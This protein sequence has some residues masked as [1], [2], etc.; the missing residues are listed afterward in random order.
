MSKRNHN[1]IPTWHMRHIHHATL[2]YEIVRN[3]NDHMMKHDSIE[4][5]TVNASAKNWFSTIN[6][7][8]I[9]M[10]K[11]RKSYFVHLP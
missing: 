10:Y 8:E 11:I 5:L 7:M 9:A 6:L 1:I 2:L 3:N 4:A